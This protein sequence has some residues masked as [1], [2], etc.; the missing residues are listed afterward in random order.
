M[1][2]DYQVE[3]IKQL[4]KQAFIHG[5]HDLRSNR[6]DDWL[7]TELVKLQYGDV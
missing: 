3:Q 2:E 6:F 1:M 4:C 5:Q 7:E